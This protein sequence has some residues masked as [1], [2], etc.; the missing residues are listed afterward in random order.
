MEAALGELETA[1]VVVPIGSTTRGIRNG[2]DQVNNWLQ[3]VCLQTVN[4]KIHIYHSY[5]SFCQFVSF[6]SMF[7]H[8]KSQKAGIYNTNL[9]H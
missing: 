4:Y 9:F 3:A 2:T 5:K 8:N 6:K 1:L 7:T